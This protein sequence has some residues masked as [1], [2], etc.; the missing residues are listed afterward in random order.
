M[1]KILEMRKREKEKSSRRS[2]SNSL[3]R[4]DI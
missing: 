3:E 1:A 2:S 4:H